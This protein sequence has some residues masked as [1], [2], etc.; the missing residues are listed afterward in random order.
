MAVQSEDTENARTTHSERA[1]YRRDGKEAESGMFANG[2]TYS[3]HP[4]V[5]AAGLKN[6]EIMGRDNFMEHVREVGPYFQA[7]LRELSDIPIV[8]EVRG[9]GLMACVE[10]A[11]AP[12][13]AARPVPTRRVRTQARSVPHL[14]GNRF[15]FP[16][17]GSRRH[18]THLSTKIPTSVPATAPPSI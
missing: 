1:R 12:V 9:M 17:H 18:P 13:A 6:L 3:G 10:C 4:V 16:S 11:L 14:M 8:G 15:M 5:C 2:F 7:R